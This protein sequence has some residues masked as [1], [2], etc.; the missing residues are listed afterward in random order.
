MVGYQL[1]HDWMKKLAFLQNAGARKPPD[2]L[3]LYS[4]VPA[5]SMYNTVKLGGCQLLS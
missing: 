3:S 4:I 5:L 1:T 2:L